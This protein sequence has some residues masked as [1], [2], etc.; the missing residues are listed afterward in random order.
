MEEKRY[1]IR[2]LTPCECAR[3]MGFTKEDDDKL[4][5]VGISATQRYKMY[6][7]GIITNCVSLLFEHL[8]KAQYDPRYE[9]Y[10]ENFTQAAM[11]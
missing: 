8:F 2:K 11:V 4:A 3:L 7:N 1:R 10:D 5:A 6:G 9:C